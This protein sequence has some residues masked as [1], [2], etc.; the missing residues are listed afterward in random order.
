MQCDWAALHNC[1]PGSVVLC[2]TQLGLMDVLLLHRGAAQQTALQPPDGTIGSSW[3][4]APAAHLQPLPLAPATHHTS[5]VSLA[6][7]AYRHVNTSLF[8]ALAW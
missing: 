7:L 4:P 6:R 3:G 8:L 5:D 2:E 1:R